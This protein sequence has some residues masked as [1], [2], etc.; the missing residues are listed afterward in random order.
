MITHLKKLD[1]DIFNVE[2]MKLCRYLAVNIKL[3]R[4]R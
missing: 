1:I 4:K 3:K 2:S